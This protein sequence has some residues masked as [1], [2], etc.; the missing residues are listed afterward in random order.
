MA[1]LNYQFS[2]TKFL[3]VENQKMKHQYEFE[4]LT[5]DLLQKELN[6]TL[7]NFKIG[8]DKGIDLRYIKHGVNLIIQ[9]KHYANSTFNDL[10]T[11][12][13]KEVPKVETLSPNWYIVP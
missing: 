9:C 4:I 6:M 7:E 13:K 1:K 12:L 3:S 11:A 10:Q 2:S 8:R 5:R